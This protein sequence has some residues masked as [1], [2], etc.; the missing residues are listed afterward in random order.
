[1]CVCMCVCMCMRVCVHA[2]M[3]VCESPFC[4]VKFHEQETSLQSAQLHYWVYG[5]QGT[6]PVWDFSG[7]SKLPGCYSDAKSH[8]TLK[9]N[10][11]CV[12]NWGCICPT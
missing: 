10:V 8:C 4:V 9:F 1:V 6:K 11:N 2:C 3:H 12:R 7:Q 5:Q